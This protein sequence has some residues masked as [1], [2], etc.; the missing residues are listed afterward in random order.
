LPPLTRAS[1]GNPL[2]IALEEVAGGKV[3]ALPPDESEGAPAP[4]AIGGEDI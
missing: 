4:S 1:S 3:V 2:T